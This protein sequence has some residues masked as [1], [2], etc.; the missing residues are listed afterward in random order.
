MHIPGR[1]G[2]NGH[3]TS[4]P[5]VME[6]GRVVMKKLL[7]LLLVLSALMGLAACGKQEEN[8]AETDPLEVAVDIPG[9]TA[10]YEFQEET[11]VPETE[12]AEE[13]IPTETSRYI[14]DL[15]P[16]NSGAATDYVWQNKYEWN[17]DYPYLIPIEFE[18]LPEPETVWATRNVNIRVEPSS[19][20]SS[21]GDLCQ[22]DSATRVGTSKDG[23]SALLIDDTIMYVASK[24]VTAKDPA[25][26]AGVNK[27][28][29][30]EAKPG[31]VYTTQKVRMRMGPGTDTAQVTTLPPK[32][33]LDRQ[34]VC[35]NGWNKVSYEGKEG[36]VSGDY[37]TETEYK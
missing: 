35:S 5:E 1:M 29:T 8:I 22:G 32:A 33:K 9:T 30:E 19:R 21:P 4:G 15:S 14:Y 3:E 20:S 26:P 10:P 34:A 27:T 31:V 7:A 2:Y 25:K 36:Y 37:L 12:A 24:Y 11:A 28:I 18:I 23:W 6:K 13:V 16:E 17:P